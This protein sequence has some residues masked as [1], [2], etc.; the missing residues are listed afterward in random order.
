[1]D[2]VFEQNPLEKKHPFVSM[3]SIQFLHLYFFGG[4]LVRGDYL[5]A[6]WHCPFVSALWTEVYQMASQII[7]GTIE[8]TI[9]S[10]LSSLPYPKLA[11]GLSNPGSNLLGHC[12][13]LASPLP[14]CHFSH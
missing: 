1:M 3:P 8:P 12:F 13:T 6:W 9:E 5:H 11:S 2:Q 10:A 7:G 4:C 14:F